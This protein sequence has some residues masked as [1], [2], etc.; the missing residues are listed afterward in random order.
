MD[1]RLFIEAILGGTIGGFTNIK[2]SDNTPEVVRI[3][4]NLYKAKILKADKPNGN[5]RIYSR[6]LIQKMISAPLP[7]NGMIDSAAFVFD[8]IPPQLISHTVSKLKL[9]GDY[10]TVLIT[11][12]NTIEGKRLQ[13]LLEQKKIVFRPTGSSTIKENDKG[14][15]TL[16]DDYVLK[17]INAYEKDIAAGL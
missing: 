2:V 9:E 8:K 12:L 11:P 5:A 6:S 10:L 4:E 17:A 13:N 1:R 3:N 15:I 14:I 7:P 16:N